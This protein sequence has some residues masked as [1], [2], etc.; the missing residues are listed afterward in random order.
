MLDIVFE[1]HYVVKPICSPQKGV[2]L[3]AFPASRRAVQHEGEK[4]QEGA[5]T[6]PQNQSEPRAPREKSKHFP[7]SFCALANKLVLHALN[8]AVFLFSDATSQ[9]S[10]AAT[11]GLVKVLTLVNL[12]ARTLSRQS[13]NVNWNNKQDASSNYVHN[14]IFIFTDKR[15]PVKAC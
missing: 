1:I 3:L 10:S 15:V 11:L 9:N 4:H 14:K 7:L 13:L 6:H 5:D 8:E 2:G 12:R